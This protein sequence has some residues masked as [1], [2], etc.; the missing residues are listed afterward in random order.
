MDFFH[1]I[2]DNKFIILGISI[3]ANLLLIILCGWLFYQKL[4]MPNT[5]L[6]TKESEIREAYNEE[7]IEEDNSFFVEI[8]GAVQ[9]PGVYK[10]NSDNIINDVISL[11]G[12]FT[13]DAYTDNINLSKKVEKELVIYVYNKSEFLDSKDEVKE[14]SKTYDIS[15]SIK[16]KNSEILPS[17]KEENKTEINGKVNINT[18]SVSELTKLSGIG[19]KKAALIIEYRNTYGGFKS[20]DELKNVKG[21]GDATFTK[22]KDQITV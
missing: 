16:E 2:K 3:I 18:A 7:V 13:N 15:S 14:E 8:K 17:T 1:F 5:E 12:G 9:N 4:S 10:V 6:N 21:I 20:I 22:I 19:D 11:A